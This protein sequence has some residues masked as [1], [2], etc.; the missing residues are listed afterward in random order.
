MGSNPLIYVR[1]ECIGTLGCFTS[2]KLC[3]KWLN[4]I[5]GIRPVLLTCKPL[6]NIGKVTFTWETRVSWGNPRPSLTRLTAGKDRHPILKTSGGFLLPLKGK[7]SAAL[8]TRK[9]V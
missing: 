1:R 9:D 4:R 6:Y 7:V 5:K 8:L 3:G 2:S